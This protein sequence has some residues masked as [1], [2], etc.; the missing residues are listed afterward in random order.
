M[1]RWI[2]ISLLLLLVSGCGSDS[3]SGPDREVIVVIPTGDYI[4]GDAVTISAQVSGFS[5]IDRVA[6]Y[7]NNN[8]IQSDTE[9]PYQ[10]QLQNESYEPGQRLN[11]HAVLID[12]QNEAYTSDTVPVQYMPFPFHSEMLDDFD[13]ITERDLNGNLVGQVDARDWVIRSLTPDRIHPGDRE[14]RAFGI[15]SVHFSNTGDTI[16]IDWTTS[17]ESGNDGFHLHRGLTGSAMD[18]GDAINLTA[19]GIIPGAGTS[20]LLNEYTWLDRYRVDFF[21]EYF[22]WLEAVDNQPSPTVHFLG[23]YTPTPSDPQ[24]ENAL[25]SAYPN[26]ALESC[27]FAFSLN[28]AS[29]V[30]LMVVREDSSVADVTFRS[31]Q[32]AVMDYLEGSPI[33]APDYYIVEW[34]TTFLEN[35]LYRVIVFI[36]TTP[37]SWWGYGDILVE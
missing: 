33:L 4:W 11:I 6:F 5:G 22:Y 20:D 9:S 32:G 3:S 13:G 28:Q 27:R 2:P 34:D 18:D 30:Y 24:Y 15:H 29:V 26:P 12:E 14:Q 7:A 10:C 21:S 1:M 37:V 8:L 16:R 35:A 25:I 36:E 19:G 17:Y 31:D 23:S